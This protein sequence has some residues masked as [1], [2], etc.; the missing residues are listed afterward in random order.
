MFRLEHPYYLVGLLILIPLFIGYW[1]QWKRAQK[2]LVTFASTHLWKSLVPDFAISFARR[3]AWLWL[4]GIGLIILALANPQWGIRK[5]K[6]EI[7]STDIYLALD[8]SNSMLAED[9]KPNRLERTKLWAESFVR[10]LA[11]DRIGIVLFA[12]HA[13]LQSPLTTDYGSAALFIRSAQPDLITTQGT[14]ISDAIA[15]CLENFPATEDAQKV[16][17]LLSDGENHDELASNIGAQAKAKN[18]V[19]YTIGTATEQ[20]GLIPISQ[21]GMQDYKRDETGAPIQSKLDA[22]ILRHIASSTRGSYH[23]I[24]AGNASILQIKSE[25]ADMTKQRVAERAY[26]EYES[27]FIYLLIP[28]II[29]L[30]L[31]FLFTVHAFHKKVSIP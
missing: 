29:C 16:I 5:E 22:A 17:I 1:Y 18:V 8:I 10:E 15:T 6:I 19:I 7:K 28:G 24:E 3:N 30:V 11:N 20:G 2:R 31:E 14:N 26:T 23:A 9:I 4:A 12:G 27:Y 25:I 21:Q 13:F